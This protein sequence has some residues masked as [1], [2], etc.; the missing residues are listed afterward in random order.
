MTSNR[1]PSAWA[2]SRVPPAVSS[3]RPAK[4][5]EPASATPAP[6]DPGRSVCHA[7]GTTADSS[8]RRPVA[9]S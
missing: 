9:R 7:N 6:S 2:R 4:P 5:R 8:T 1:T 3:V